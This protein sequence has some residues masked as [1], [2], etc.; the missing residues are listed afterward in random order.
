MN[1]SLPLESIFFDALEKTSA[2]ERS[3]FLDEACAGD[4]DL[5]QSVERMEL[6]KGVPITKYCDDKQLPVRARLE[7]LL[8]VC[9]A[10]Q[11]AHQKGLIHRDIKPSNVLVAEDDKR[12][13]CRLENQ[14]RRARRQRRGATLR[15]PAV[16]RRARAGVGDTI[17]VRVRDRRR[18]CASHHTTP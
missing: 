11:H 17:P 7:L 14:L 18:F 1:S 6:V 9:Q 13:V 5:R 12:A 4:T 3:A 8:P 15:Q 16:G 2:A 10:I